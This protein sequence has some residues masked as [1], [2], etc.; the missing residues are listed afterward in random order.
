MN[1]EKKI[2]VKNYVA[3]LF[4]Q[5]ANFILPLIIL[6]Y[7][8]RV[9]GSE[10]YGLVM[11]AQ[12]VAL[13]LTIV[14]DFG[15]NISAT[16]EVA[17][18]KDDKEKLSQFYWNIVFIKFVLIIVTFIILLGMTYFIDKFKLDPLVYLFSFGLVIGQAIFP[19]W[20]FQ[21]I[22]KMQVITIVTV[23]A[24][25]F[26]TLSLFFVV[27]GPEIMCMSQYLMV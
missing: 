21:G 9:L 6:P 25:L 2:I 26:F 14:V 23:G 1:K 12:S 24:K 5:G 19:T 20:F 15:F 3:L 16:K 10:K 8:V 4:I 7:L 18:I 13:F 27:F 11:I 17:S 22:Q